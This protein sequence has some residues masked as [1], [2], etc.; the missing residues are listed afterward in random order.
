MDKGIS[1]GDIQGIGVTTRLDLLY[2][3][4]QPFFDIN[5]CAESQ[6]SRFGTQLCQT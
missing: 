2:D 6:T 4:L 3:I 1:N 5:K